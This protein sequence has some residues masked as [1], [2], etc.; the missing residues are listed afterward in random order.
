M[1]FA[2]PAGHK[3]LPRIEELSVPPVPP[4]ELLE[5]ILVL[6]K[7]DIH[8]IQAN[9][10]DYYHSKPTP[11]QVRGNE[12]EGLRHA[13]EALGRGGGLRGTERAPTS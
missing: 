7:Y 5:R 9:L 3:P 1:V 8:P 2:P 13:E 11:E 6:H 10:S 4:A 12:R